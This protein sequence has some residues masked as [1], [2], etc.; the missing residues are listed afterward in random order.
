[1]NY[2]AVDVVETSGGKL[3]VLEIN[4]TPTFY[5]FIQLWGRE[6]FGIILEK[7]ISAKANQNQ[8]LDILRDSYQQLEAKVEVPS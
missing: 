2:A 3:Q 8:H 7:L 1:M 5:N 4:S 6:K